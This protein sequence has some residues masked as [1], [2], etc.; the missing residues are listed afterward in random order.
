[1]RASEELQK[2]R[3]GAPA[4]IYEQEGEASEG[5]LFSGSDPWAPMEAADREVLNDLEHKLF[6][7][8]AVEA[9]LRLALAE[10]QPSAEEALIQPATLRGD[11]ST[12]EA[13]R[14]R[15][16]AAI[17]TGVEPDATAPEL[18]LRRERA[19]RL[20]KQIAALEAQGRPASDASAELE[21]ELRGYLADWRGLLRN[22][23]IIARQMI[24]KVLDGRL[25]F[26]PEE[27]EDGRRYRFMGHAGIGRLVLA[28]PVAKEVVTPG[29]FAGVSTLELHGVIR[30][31]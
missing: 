27:D 6:A 22:Q 5:G 21:Q 31:A 16:A 1:M 11:L 9:G 3:L 30:V 26:M 29:G 17:A 28:T 25:I 4:R 18:N 10:V 23:A 20:R 14:A 13:E 2:R 19:D 12:V 15:L 7:P 8:D 24:A